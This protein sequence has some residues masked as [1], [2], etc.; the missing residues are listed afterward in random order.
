MTVVPP[1]SSDAATC[2]A[3]PTSG[4]PLPLAFPVAVDRAGSGVDT[5]V[6]PCCALHAWHPGRLERLLVGHKGWVERGGTQVSKSGRRKRRLRVRAIHR[7]QPDLA[8]LARALIEIAVAQVEA[9]AQA[10]HES[11]IR[12]ENP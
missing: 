1:R 9:E 3:C 8:K 5:E 7:E 11:R 6:I 12:K 4:Q 2:V 10:E